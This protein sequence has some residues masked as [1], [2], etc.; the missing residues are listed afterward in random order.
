HNL[1]HRILT[2]GALP[3]PSAIDVIQQAAAA[4]TLASNQGIIHRDIKPQ[5]LLIGVDN[6]V[7]LTDFGLARSHESR[8]ITV[9]G[10]FVASPHYVASEQVE[11]SHRADTRA[12]LYSLGCVF[13][14]AL[15]A[16]VP[17]VVE[18]AWDLVILHSFPPRRSSE[19][20]APCLLQPSGPESP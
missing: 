14:E 20:G 8:D 11:N 12:D 4:I 3:V 19:R 18:H 13:F 2:G 16:R 10:F 5:N 17:F 1:K 15:T 6:V 7:R 9:P